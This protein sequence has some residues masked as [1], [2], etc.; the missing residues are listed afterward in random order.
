VSGT[1]CRCGRPTAG[2]WLCER[3][4]KTLEVAVAN[5]GV[6]HADLDTLRTKRERYG[7]GAATKGSIGKAQPLGMDARF[8][9]AQIGSE[10]DYDTRN[11]VVAWVRTIM[12]EQPQI[13]GPY[14]RSACLHVSCGVIFRRRYP[15]DTIQSMT[16]YL[17]RQ[18]RWI[19]GQRWCE[20]M[21]DELLDVEQRLAR[22][23]DRPPDRWYAGKCSAPIGEDG[24]LC[25]AELYAVNEKGSILCH[26]CG[27]RH[28]VA[29]RRDFLLDEAREVHVTATEAASALLAWTDYDGS[30]TKLVDLI[31]RWR[32]R[33]RLD[34][35]DVTSLL[36]KDRHLYRLGD[37]Q[38][39]LVEHAQ[40]QQAK[41]MG[42]SA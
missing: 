29:Q 34:V 24:D 39:L 38:D 26:T 27:E 42:R 18:R 5:I 6:Y 21:L 23:I 3:C 12:E 20:D 11:T 17:L 2:A 9:K 10:V 33:E 30:E 35:A 19:V 4:V 25:P 36:G 7:S 16:A 13:I 31:R 32:D 28:D 22:L 37:I 40:R 41:R 1:T 14:C 15:A 8:G